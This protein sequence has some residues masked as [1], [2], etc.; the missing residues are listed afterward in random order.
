MAT[1]LLYRLL[2]SYK[3]M[4]RIGPSYGHG[5]N[6]HHFLAIDT[7]EGRLHFHVAK[8]SLATLLMIIFTPSKQPAIISYYAIAF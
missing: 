1:F 5:E 8:G 6:R 3:A 2:T 4:S 7:R